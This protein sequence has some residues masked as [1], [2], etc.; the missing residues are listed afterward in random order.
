[1]NDLKDL[2]VADIIRSEA[3]AKG[4][5]TAA[6]HRGGGADEDDSIV[7]D[8]PHDPRPTARAWRMERERHGGVMAASDGQ[9]AG[10][11]FSRRET[12]HRCG[13]QG[14]IQ[15]HDE[16]SGGRGKERERR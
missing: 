15:T 11:L 7:K 16:E 10:G 12:R 6:G 8:A 3:F 2:K 1:M 14:S 5:T 4:V 9:D 13:V